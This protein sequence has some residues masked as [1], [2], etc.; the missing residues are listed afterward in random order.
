MSKM[1]ELYSFEKVEKMLVKGFTDDGLSTEE[2][3]LA[4]FIDA[5]P[6]EVVEE[7]MEAQKVILSLAAYVKH[8]KEGENE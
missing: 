7:I 3:F 4:D 1:P 6:R 2:E 8:L 5:T